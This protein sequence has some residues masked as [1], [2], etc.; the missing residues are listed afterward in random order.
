MS[1]NK[2]H[3]LEMGAAEVSAF[4]TH[5]AV[6]G[7]MA[8]SARNAAYASR[9]VGGAALPES[10]AV[11]VRRSSPEHQT[12][13]GATMP[14]PRSLLLISCLLVAAVTA[15]ACA[16]RRVESLD[17][18]WQF[19]VEGAGDQWKSIGLPA[20]FE[21]HEGVTFDGVGIYRRQVPRAAIPEGMRAILHFQAV[22]T[23]AEAWL[24]D[25]HLG[26][27]LGGWTP[28]R[29]DVTELMRAD[30][31]GSH[32]LRVRVDEMVGHNSQGFLP[33]VCPHF[34]GIW[35]DVRLLIVPDCWIDDLRLLAVGDPA[36]GSI[37]VEFPV[38]GTPNGPD[39]RV[40]ARYRLLGD[41]AWSPGVT[42]RSKPFPAAESGSNRKDGDERR[43]RVIRFDVPV[44]DWKWWSPEQPNLYELELRL[45]P[46]G[47][48]ASGGDRVVVRA[49]FRTIRVD[50]ERLLLNDIP[51][52]VR[53]L[54]NW[55]Y[56]PP[57]VAPTLDEASMR[58]DLEL[59]RSYGFNLMKFCLWVP[60]KRYLELA[61]ELG[62]LTWMEYPT[63]H[64]RWS[65]DQL[66]TLRK[67]F[68]EFFQFD[69]NHPS[70]VLRSLTCET[71]PSA[72]L[73]VMRN[74]YDLC[75][76]MIPGCVVEDDSS[77]IAWNRVHDFY[78]DHPYGNNHTWVATLQRLK[79]HI[80]KHG[81][82]PL[83]LGEAIC[84]DT[85]IDREA[86]LRRCG[87]STERPFWAPAHLD[88]TDRWLEQVR[89]LAGQEGLDR[90]QSDSL[91]YG[92]L[93]RKYQAETFRREVPHGGYV[94]SVI[95]DIPKAS[96][97]LIDF[98]EQP[99][100]MPED[101]Q[102][103]RDTLCILKTE[104][105]R[106]GFVA[107]QPIRAE[108]LVSHFGAHPLEDALLNV[109]LEPPRAAKEFDAR[110]I[111]S[112]VSQEAGTLR[113]VLDLSFPTG[114]VDAPVRLTIRAE[115]R[116]GLD[117]FTNEWPIWL[118]PGSHPTSP[119][120]VSVH[121]SFPTELTDS[122]FSAAPGFEPRES[123]L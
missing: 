107:G 55:G 37:R 90:L 61:D 49:A 115:L 95:R 64:S 34:G 94:M 82:K 21:E 58:R 27:H 87:D 35:Q 19:Q 14:H 3:P 1:H 67:E 108:F 109:T 65:A 119:E 99:K 98:L 11:N 86:I 18:E 75:H 23:L 101:W 30:T 2:H 59:A 10:F 121:P 7:H 28:F 62:M 92:M 105:D 81:A 53:G 85:W 112:S 41:R 9:L 13:K 118:V 22:A 33:I 60:P 29:F 120:N 123:S 38:E 20:S 8:A 17:G 83:V 56:A 78:D 110:E 116:A 76:A 89:E 96:M 66:P 63:W 12:N 45:I 79:D 43:A 57:R 97:G 68:T 48:D 104:N 93:M 113:K 77:W 88:D 72:D 44:D 52:S 91:Q 26:S 6:D 69:R 80:A 39:L 32:E 70:V 117:T 106:R 74:L 24:D 122:L 102:W 54:L 111:R 42:V 73:N 51:L 31:A 16:D 50:G 15:D 36:S 84:A 100:W 47:G 5:L 4:L 71:G 46:A 114:A 25:T 103:Q 40:A